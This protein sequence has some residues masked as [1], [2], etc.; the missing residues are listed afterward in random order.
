MIER[1]AGRIARVIVLTLAVSF[2]AAVVLNFSNVVGRYLFIS[3]A[4]T[5]M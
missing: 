3:G 4:W 5:E 2:L 1:I